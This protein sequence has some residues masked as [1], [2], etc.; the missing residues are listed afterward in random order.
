M[1]PT[2]P[3]AL[4]RDPIP[5]E[6]PT[7]TES[8]AQPPA[9][10]MEGSDPAEELRLQR[11]DDE[12]WLTS[13]LGYQ[14]QVAEVL[15]EPQREKPATIAPLDAHPSAERVPR[16]PEANGVTCGARTRSGMV[17][18]RSDLYAGGRCDLHG[19][20]S[21]GP[22]TEQGRRQSAENGKM[23]GRPRKGSVTQV[24]IT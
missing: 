1:S 2:V 17:C 3:I 7:L 4:F 24:P 15:A 19:G 23:G 5:T 14:G 6:L 16:S 22:K 21:T 18:M 11:E 20:L 8:T 12:A 13:G 9:P 10:P